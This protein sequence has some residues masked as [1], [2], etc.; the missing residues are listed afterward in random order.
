MKNELPFQGQHRIPQIYLKQFGYLKNNEWYVSVYEIGKKT[1]SIEKINNFTKEINIYDLPFDELKGRRLFENLSSLIEDRF[2]KIISNLEYQKKL[3]L[4][5]SQF[6]NTIIANFICRSN[7][8]RENLKEIINDNESLKLLIKKITKNKDEYEKL[9]TLVKIFKPEYQINIICYHI[10]FYLTLVLG[11]FE[12]TIIQANENLGWLTTDNPV[13]I[14]NDNYL[15]SIESEIFFPISNKYLLFMYHPKST[16]V[17]QNLKNLKKCMVNKID[18][19]T[20]K[21]ITNKVVFNYNRYL[22][23]N[24]EMQIFDVTKK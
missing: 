19:A 21:E 9:Y 15:L 14:T 16:K 20:F 12:K 8:F 13:C 23:F 17:K 22:I 24:N 7:S 18:S 11:Q 4:K 1:T 2:P 3:I 5:D 10:V 6:L